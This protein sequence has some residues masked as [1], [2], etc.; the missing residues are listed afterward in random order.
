MGFDAIVHGKKIEVLVPPY[1]ADI[2]HQFDIVEDIAYAYG[3]NN[4]KPE[5]PNVATYG[6]ALPVEKTCEKIR[7][8]LVDIGFQEVLNF[9][10]SNQNEQFDK[11][12]AKKR[13]VVEIANPVSENYTCL[14]VWLLPSLMRIL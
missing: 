4:L 9:T 14:R 6:K 8:I 7:H 12:N 2:L 13:K 11:M 10:M 1:R 3:L 5:L